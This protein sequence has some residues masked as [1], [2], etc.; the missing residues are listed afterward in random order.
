M[1]KTEGVL[2]VLCDK[3]VDVILENFLKK[4][5][6]RFLQPKWQCIFNS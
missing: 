5:F 6:V 4:Y 2:E 3:I 1:S